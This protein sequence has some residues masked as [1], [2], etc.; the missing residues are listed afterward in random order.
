MDSGYQRGLPDSILRSCLL[1]LI[2]KQ[3][4][5]GDDLVARLRSLSLEVEDNWASLYRALRGLQDEG[6]IRSRWETGE[7]G[8]ARRVYHL[9]PA[10]DQLLVRWLTA[11]RETSPSLARHL[12]RH[13]LW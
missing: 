11:L 8:S 2:R 3:P 12:Q 9:T 13:E 10:G 1:L 6:A 4:G 7:D 5:H